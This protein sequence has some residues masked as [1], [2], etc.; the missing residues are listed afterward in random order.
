MRLSSLDQRGIPDRGYVEV[1]HDRFLVAAYH[2]TAQRLVFAGVDLLVRHV[3]GDIDEIAGAR[4]GGELE[5]VAPAHP[6][7]AAQ[8]VDHALQRAVVMRSGPGAGLDLHGTGPDPVGPGRYA[9]DRGLS[10]HTG[11][12][13]CVGVELA[14]VHNPYAKLTPVT[15]VAAHCRLRTCAAVSVAGGQSGCR[16]AVPSSRPGISAWPR[17]RRPS[18]R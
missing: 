11:R 15:N 13:R 4:F 5:P 6:C 14:M 17:R 2:N 12:L 3:R 10:L 9:A 8:D 18:Q 16:A 7:T 1:H